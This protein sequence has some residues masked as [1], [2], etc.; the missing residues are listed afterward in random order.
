MSLMRL[1]GTGSFK[2]YLGKELVIFEPGVEKGVH[3]RYVPVLLK[4]RTVSGQPVFEHLSEVKE[5]EVSLDTSEK[6]SKKDK[7]AATR[8]KN[9]KRERHKAWEEK[10][11]ETEEKRAPQEELEE[12]PKEPEVQKEEA[13]TEQDKEWANLS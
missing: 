6:A 4:Y 7:L 10:G 1:V 9:I 3:P 12:G 5:V 8:A 11:L 13:L 2:V